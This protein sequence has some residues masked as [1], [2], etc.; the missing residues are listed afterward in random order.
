MRQIIVVTDPVTA[1]GFELV[2]VEVRA[3]RDENAARKEIS[4]ILAEE[5]LDI[6]MVNDHFLAGADERLKHRMESSIPPSII[7]LPVGKTRSRSMVN[8]T[9]RKAISDYEAGGQK[10]KGATHHDAGLLLPT[11]RICDVCGHQLETG[12]R[13]CDRC[14]S[15]KRPSKTIGRRKEEEKTAWCKKCG[16][17]I[18]ERKTL[19]AV[20]TEEQKRGGVRG[21]SLAARM[22]SIG[23]FV[24]RVLGLEKK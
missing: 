13:I 12:M 1:S 6:L 17:E 22:K 24:R 23:R 9:A 3:F 20:C 10:Q 7:S 5:N 14:G 8:R 18:P 16:A 19:C 21:P 2:G 15:I 11:D 4:R